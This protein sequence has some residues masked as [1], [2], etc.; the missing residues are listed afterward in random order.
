MNENRKTR[1]SSNVDKIIHAA[2]TLAIEDMHMDKD[3]INNLLLVAQKEKTID[4]CI[5]ELDALYGRSTK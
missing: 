4:D 1:D 2:A 3:I 5:K